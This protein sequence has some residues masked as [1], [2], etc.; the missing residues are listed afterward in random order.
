[1][2]FKDKIIE[3]LKEY[4]FDYDNYSGVIALLNLSKNKNDSYTKMQEYLK[5]R[6]TRNDI[7]EYAFK[8]SDV[9]KEHYIIVSE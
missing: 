1:M 5:D 3:K 9:K 8:V 2:Q 4:G 7:F 6:H